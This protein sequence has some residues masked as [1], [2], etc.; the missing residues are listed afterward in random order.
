MFTY[1]R[2]AYYHET[3][4]MGI[5]HHSNYIKWMEE[6]R[7][8]FMD[9]LG[10][11]YKKAEDMGMGSPV[12]S[13]SIDYKHPC[14]FLDEIEIRIWV[15]KYAAIAV[16]FKYEFFNKTK[17]QVCTTATSKHCF[18]KDGKIVI[19]KKDMPALDAIIRKCMEENPVEK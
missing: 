10:W 14:D 3:D 12:T 17:N 19:V 1:T 2:K 18:V 11:G 7:L 6:A 15:E 9:A 5:I 13:L 4:K 8:E 16:E